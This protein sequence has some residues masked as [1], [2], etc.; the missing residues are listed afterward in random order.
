MKIDNIKNAAARV[1]N[2]AKHNP[3]TG[4]RATGSGAS[5]AAS[6]APPS[7]NTGAAANVNLSSQLQSVMEQ[8]GDVAVFDAKKVDE[9]KAAIANGNFKIDAGK[10]ADGLLKTVSELLQRPKE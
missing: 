4:A 6:G 5:G 3:A 1:T 10:V 7:G 9:I 2:E 8:V